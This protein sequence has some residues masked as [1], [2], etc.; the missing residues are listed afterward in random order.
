M[1]GNTTRMVVVAGGANIDI[2]GQS[3]GPLAFRDSNPGTVTVS[4][5]GVGRNIAHNLRLLGAPVCL[6]TALGEDA[7]AQELERSCRVLGIDLSAA[8]RVPGGRTST[9]VFLSD[10]RGDMALA[11]SDMALYDQLTPDYF[12]QRL[13]LLNAAAL[14]VVDTN[15][16]KASLDYLAQHCTAPLFADPVST[17]KAVKLLGNLGRLH[18]LKPNRL[19]AELLSGVAIGADSRGLERAAQT[20]LDTGLQR[21]FITLGTEGIYAAQGTQRCFLP[22][23]PAKI[24]SA[25]GGGDAFMAGLAWAYLRGE[26][27][28]ETTRLALAAATIAVEGAQTINP[29]LSPQAVRA[30]RFPKQEETG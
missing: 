16:P 1:N 20:L 18:T 14:V 26:S 10:Q 30:R 17:K 6:L 4:L 5:G 23:L 21:V 9:Y 7:Y 28:N 8:L 19:E 15:L 11:V 3:Q 2:G 29:A 13:D 24:R 27:L 12:A 25:T 22:A